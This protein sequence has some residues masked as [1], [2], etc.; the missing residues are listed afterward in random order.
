[1]PKSQDIVIWRLLDGKAGHENQVLGLSEAVGRRRSCLPIDVDVSGRL[2]GFRSW[3]PGRIHQLRG[4]PHPDLLIGAG[5]STHLP[6]LALQRQ[7]GGRT[8]MLMKPTLPTGWFN[9]CFIPSFHE[10]R[11]RSNLVL[12]EGT[13]NRI[14]PSNDLSESRGLVL[15]GGPSSHFAWSD[16]M[17]LDQLAAVCLSEPDVTWT[18][19]T[20]RRTPASFI[21]SWQQSGLPGKLIP[22]HQ[23]SF[24]WLAEQ[25]QSSGKVWVTCESISMIFQSLT[26]G[27]AVGLLEL[28][29]Q[30]RSRITRCIEQLDETG[31][32]TMCRRWQQ[33]RILERSG[34]RLAEADRCADELLKR[35]GFAEH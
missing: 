8:V 31:M 14:L 4:L 29:V 11:P 19:T 20:S 2:K 34:L 15:L 22:F 18:L 5:H 35:F 21:H 10:L 16:Q 9:L 32:V 26:A 3:L 13:L 12:T 33:H 6:L 17:V 1:M 7:F 28:P 24:R 25:M 23:T 30:K 27:A